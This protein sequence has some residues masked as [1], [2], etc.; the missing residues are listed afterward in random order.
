MRVAIKFCGRDKSGATYGITTEDGARHLGL[1]W[2]DAETDRQIRRE[3]G[4]SGGWFTRSDDFIGH[5]VDI[6]FLNNA[7][8]RLNDA[9]AFVRRV[10]AELEPCSAGC[11]SLTKSGGACAK[12]AKVPEVGKLRMT[13][14]QIKALHD[15]I[16]IFR[17]DG[18]WLA[19]FD[20]AKAAGLALGCGHYFADISGELTV[21]CELPDDAEAAIG[22]IVAQGHR[23]AICEAVGHNA[24]NGLA[25][26]RVAACVHGVPIGAYCARCFR[27]VTAVPEVSCPKCVEAIASG[28]RV[29]R[30]DSG[31]LAC[32]DCAGHRFMD[33]GYWENK[34]AL[35]AEQTRAYYASQAAA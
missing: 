2:H 15:S 14:N 25:V 18:K 24:L 26:T 30:L 27:V 34:R 9:R 13:Y 28:G 10:F 1:I 12:C 33:D 11:G 3:F 19:L 31:E 35:M 5:D 23:V 6:S 16:L 29:F 21:I 8:V 20:D 22:Q 17:I 4:H 7:F 32:S